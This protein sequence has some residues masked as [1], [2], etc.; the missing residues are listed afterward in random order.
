MESKNQNKI[1]ELV[2]IVSLIIIVIGCVKEEGIKE[3]KPN[4][5]DTI[6]DSSSPSSGVDINLKLS[7]AP[8]LGETVLLNATVTVIQAD[9]VNT[10]F[11]INLPDGFELVNGGLSWEGDIIIPNKT[12]PPFNESNQPAKT[13]L[14]LISNIKAIQEG[15]WTITG[16]L[17]DDGSTTDKFQQY[18]RLYVSVSETN[19]YISDTPFPEP[20]EPCVDRIIDGELVRCT[21]AE[22]TGDFIETG[23]P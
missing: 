7:K 11:S 22:P 20:T 8:L 1:F 17:S 13:S 3:Y 21:T 12:Y 23:Q 15:E 5:K 19:S 16:I 2:L 9:V 14:S 6:R 10:I 4:I 18:G